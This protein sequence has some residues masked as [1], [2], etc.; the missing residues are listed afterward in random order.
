MAKTATK[1]AAKKESKPKAAAAPVTTAIEKAAET[2]L[3]KLRELGIAEELQADLE[4]CIGSFRYDQNP[5]GL[6][7]KTAEAIVLFESEKAKKT[8][9]VTAKL[10]TDLQK[11][12]STREA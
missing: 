10:I 11:A 6:F 12:I 2:A 3:V 7:D 4:W 1:T 8:K 5:A 9:G